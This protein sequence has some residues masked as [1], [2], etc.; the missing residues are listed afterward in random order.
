MVVV[1]KGEEGGELQE[2]FTAWLLEDEDV[3]KFK[4]DEEVAGSA[5]K[6]FF[7]H[8]SG[9]LIITLLYTLLI[10][11]SSQCL[12]SIAPFAR[13]I[14]LGDSPRGGSEVSDRPHSSASGVTA[15][16]VILPR[17]GLAHRNVPVNCHTGSVTLEA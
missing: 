4:G 3:Q 15:A 17:S 9:R 1:G 11:D 5:V 16:K 8:L 13:G 14:R 6:R 12:P 7:T 10:T 2:G